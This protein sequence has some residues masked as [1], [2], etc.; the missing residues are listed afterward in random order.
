MLCIKG[1]EQDGGGEGTTLMV[2]ICPPKV[3]TTAICSMSRKVSRIF[4]ALNSLKL[5]AQS[6]PC[7]RNA[8]PMAASPSRSSSFRTSPVNTSGGN[9]ARVR[10]VAS[11]AAVS[12]YS[13]ICRAGRAR[14]L[15]GVHPSVVL[16]CEA[17]RTAVSPRR[18]L[19]RGTRERGAWGVGGG[20]VARGAIVA[21]RAVARG[22]VVVTRAAAE[23]EIESKGSESEGRETLRV[24]RVQPL[25]FSRLCMWRRV[26][27][28]TTAQL[29]KSECT[30]DR[31]D[32]KKRKKTFRLGRV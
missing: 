31:V 12:G 6:P 29:H 32:K 24:Q 30:T 22:A 17:A 11:S 2:G 19:T 21:V 13:G 7:R 28:C 3:R 20:A 9:S 25:S 10:S 5:S 14:Q 26:A 16:P 1:E 4:C 8:R 18:G 27:E 23:W 15:P